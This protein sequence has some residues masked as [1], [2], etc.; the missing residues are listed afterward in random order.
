MG[1]SG[2]TCS[3]CRTRP[4]RHSRLCC[5]VEP[6]FATQ[7]LS[8][9]EASGTAHWVHL[10]GP[11]GAR[12]RPV[13]HSWCRPHARCPCPARLLPEQMEAAFQLLDQT[14]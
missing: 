14:E 7:S 12:G 9:T 3:G 1:A 8:C 6:A 11:A 5:K 13:V 4:G 2:T 10:T